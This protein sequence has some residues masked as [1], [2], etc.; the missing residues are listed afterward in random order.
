MQTN[1][2]KQ[3]YE[4]FENFLHFIR[5][6]PDK[7]N[8]FEPGN[9]MESSDNIQHKTDYELLDIR[10]IVEFVNKTSLGGLI[11]SP[12]LKFIHKMSSNELKSFS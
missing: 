3:A 9:M 8:P 6:D 2:K 12:M 4:S 10:N 11:Y 7:W 1:E 5:D